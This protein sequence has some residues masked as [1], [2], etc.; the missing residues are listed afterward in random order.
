MDRRQDE[1]EE[2]P[3]QV[4]KAYEDVYGEPLPKGMLKQVV[5]AQ[6]AEAKRKFV[7]VRFYT[8]KPE[9]LLKLQAIL[10][11]PASEDA[12]PVTSESEEAAPKRRRRRGTVAE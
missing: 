12:A 10:S 9:D 1:I 5:D 2:T 8:W 6:I 4:A 11:Q 3:Q 7:E